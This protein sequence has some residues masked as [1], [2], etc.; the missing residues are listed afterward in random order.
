MGALICVER[1]LGG[2]VVVTPVIV[3]VWMSSW[4][5]GWGHVVS[6]R[7]SHALVD[8]ARSRPSHRR[9]RVPWLGPPMAHHLARGFHMSLG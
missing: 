2:I 5:N 4:W 9:E 7:G 8:Y 3:E 6:G 1:E